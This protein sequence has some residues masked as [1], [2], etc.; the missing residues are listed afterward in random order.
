MRRLDA[1]QLRFLEETSRDYEMALME[2][3]HALSYL[4]GR[5]ISTTSRDRFRLGLVLDPPPEHEK[6]RGRLAIPSIKRSGVTGFKFRCIRA[7]CIEQDECIGHGKYITFE[8]QSMFNVMD[9][10]NDRGE[11]ATIEGEIDTIITSG[12]CDIPSVGFVGVNSWHSHYF[13]LLKDFKRIWVFKDNDPPKKRKNCKACEGE[14]V[15]HNVGNEF[16]EFLCEKFSQ[17]V[18]IE[19]PVLVQGKKS[20]ANKVFLAKGRQYL[21]DRIGYK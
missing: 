9:L 13:R 17:A 15:G 1:N 3:P 4:A 7:A 20:D 18:P 11:I 6:A 10:D 12:E 19:L 5:G 2:D 14:C 8:P 21:R 16:G